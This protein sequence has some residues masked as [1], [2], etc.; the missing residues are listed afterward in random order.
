[1]KATLTTNLGKIELEL[2]NDIAPHTVNNF[3]D[4]AEGTK[5]WTDPHTHKEVE[6]PFY[7]G[8][9]F[10]RVIKDFM[11]QGGCPIGN[12]TGGPGYTF[13]D[14]CFVEGDELK[15]EITSD[16]VA[17]RIFNEV[18]VP[19]FR[20]TPK[21]DAELIDIAQKVSQTQNPDLIKAKT[22]DYYLEKTAHQTPFIER[23]VIKG[24]DYGTICMANAGPNTNG[25]QFFIVTK[26]DGCAWL[27]GKHTVFGK[28]V[29]GM[30]VVHAIE[31][32][33][34]DNSDKPVSAAVIEKVE[35]ER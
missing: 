32:L 12:G 20:K 25:S 34:T 35:V 16:E 26:K 23:K 7:N 31:E 24:V 11:I 21:P 8:L 15:G 17:V 19:Y 6:R 1:M 9:V 2:F 5:T 13:D 14:E 18:L 10:H 28:V 30:D 33:E 29:K 27:N 22:I 4:L 3:V